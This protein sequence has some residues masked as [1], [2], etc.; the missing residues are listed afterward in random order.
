MDVG[1]TQQLRLAISLINRGDIIR[2]KNFAGSSDQI[3]HVEV[4]KVKRKK[5]F[6]S[7][8]VIDC[9]RPIRGG[10]EVCL[11]QDRGIR[12]SCSLTQLE[13]TSTRFPGI[14]TTPDLSIAGPYFVHSSSVTLE[15]ANLPG[16]TTSFHK[17]RME[18]PDHDNTHT[19]PSIEVG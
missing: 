18:L 11:N 10:R 6:D 14:P 12:R 19:I 2:A 7:R 16:T 13:Q 1:D 8:C 3:S 4:S 5:G 15:L 17:I 9:L